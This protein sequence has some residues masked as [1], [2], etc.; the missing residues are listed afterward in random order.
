[1][2]VTDSLDARTGITDFGNLFDELNAELN[3]TSANEKNTAAAAL[4]MM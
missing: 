1:M 4:R 3:A 2:S